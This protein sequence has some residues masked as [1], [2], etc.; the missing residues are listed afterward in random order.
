MCLTFARDAAGR[1][2]V[3]SGTS[4]SET[5][6]RICRKKPSWCRHAII[7]DIMHPLYHPLSGLSRVRLRVVGTARPQIQTSSEKFFSNG[8]APAVCS[9]AGGD[10]P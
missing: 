7:H 3:R 6:S 4:S 9:R 2:M 1:P 5:T 10:Q 8:S